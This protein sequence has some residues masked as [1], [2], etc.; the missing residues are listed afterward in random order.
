MAYLVIDCGTSGCRASLVSEAGEIIRQRRRVAMLSG[1]QP[2][3]GE[4]EVQEVWDQVK[5]VTSSLLEGLTDATIEAVG[6]SA[7][8]GY[9][10]LD[11]ADRPLMPATLWMDNRAW[12]EARELSCLFGL[13]ELYLRTGRRMSPELLA[14]KLFWLRRQRPETFRGIRRVLGLKDE[15]VRRLTGECVTDYAHLDYTSLW[16]VRSG[17][18]LREV[19]AALGIDPALFPEAVP[20]YAIAG[21]LT[22]RAAKETG[23]PDGTPVVVGTSDGT[24]AM[25]G[26]GVLQEGKAVLVSG[27]TDVLMTRSDRYVED[28]SRVLT[29]N[30]GMLPGTFLVGGAMGLSAGALDRLQHL[31]HESARE[32][33]PRIAAA[34]PGA[35]G[36]LFFPG[37]TGERAPYWKEHLTGGIVGL[38]VWHG[39]EHIFKALMEGCAL[40]LRRLV[41]H[42]KQ[43]GLEPQ[44]LHAVGGGAGLDVWNQIRADATG[45]EIRCP[46]TSEATT[47]GTAMFCR[48]AAQ[49]VDVLRGLARAW[50]KVN[51]S[52]APMPEHA[53]LYER[54]CGLYGLF[55]EAADPVYQ[56]LR[57]GTA[58]GGKAVP[59]GPAGEGPD[60]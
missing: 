34:G 23:I 50:V 13:D 43:N 12:R 22:S 56:G 29:V 59:S 30:R 16:D 42:L 41:D 21:H 14:P 18:P 10:F 26:G 44:C 52:Y 9:V 6:M 58:C 46:E 11:E 20:A 15:L 60:S 40:R 8:L 25:Y 48:A 39:P 1:P 31:L 37:L 47:L 28:E 24:A 53:R 45:K 2:F 49:G 33:E 35:G 27:T 55:L 5:E 54:L 38:R 36:L 19:M 32:M 3:F 17:E 4:T 57:A 51:K 7:M